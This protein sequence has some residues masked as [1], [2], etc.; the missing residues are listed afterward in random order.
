MPSIETSR[1][2]CTFQK[3]GFAALYLLLGLR[4][5]YLNRFGGSRLSPAW[6]KS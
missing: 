6:D 2:G 3:H 1:S 5:T 4:S